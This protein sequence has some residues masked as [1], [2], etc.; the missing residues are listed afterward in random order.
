MSPRMLSQD[1]RDA[2]GNSALMLAVA[3]GNLE[4]VKMLLR[5]GA[6]VEV[7]NSD[8]RTP[9]LI[10]VHAG[11]EDVVALLLEAKADP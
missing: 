7:M 5:A 6:E 9:L 4:I 2:H 3:N 1:A 10:A 8:H 11:H